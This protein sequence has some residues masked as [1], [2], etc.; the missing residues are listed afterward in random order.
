MPPLLV[1]FQLTWPSDW[2]LS[3]WDGREVDY[4]ARQRTIS[5]LDTAGAPL[6]ASITWECIPVAVLGVAVFRS[7][8]AAER[9]P[10]AVIGLPMDAG[11]TIR[12]A[13]VID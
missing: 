12:I 7:A 13:P 6:L 5:A 2:Y 3:L 9:W 4:Q 1:G 10:I 8:D 11:D